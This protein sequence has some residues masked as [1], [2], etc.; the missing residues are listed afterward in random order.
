M[1]CKSNYSCRSL[2]F[3]LLEVMIALAIISLVVAQLSSAIGQSHFALSRLEEKTLAH[4][5]A[6]NKMTEIQ[7]TPTLPR[8]G[9]VEERVEMANR[10]WRI[11]TK[12]TQTETKNLFLVEVRVGLQS[13]GGNEQGFS[14]LLRGLKGKSW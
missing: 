13:E 8:V 3:T 14:T 9:S 5:V 11:E 2:G 4:W 1:K 7:I 10:R 12:T 6:M